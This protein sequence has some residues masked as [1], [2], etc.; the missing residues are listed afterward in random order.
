MTLSRHLVLLGLALSPVVANA[1]PTPP[2]TA[3]D[4]R[5]ILAIYDQVNGFDIET[6]SLGA[7]M[8]P[9]QDVRGLAVMV[10]RDHSAVRQMSRDLAQRLGIVYRV[11]EGNSAATSHGE[12]LARLRAA[13]GDAFDRAYLAHEIEFHRNAIKAVKETLLPAAS[14][15]DLRKLIGDVLPGFEQHLSHTLEVA[16]RHGI[17]VR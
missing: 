9:S 10:L 14:N 7:E 3:L 13:E 6:A 11:P 8:S 16:A 5:T 1:S 12:A 4:D 17:S 15:P 2:A